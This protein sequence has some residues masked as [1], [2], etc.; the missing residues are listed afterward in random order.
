MEDFE[1]KLANYF[2]TPSGKVLIDGV[3]TASTR[4]LIAFEPCPMPPWLSSRPE[5]RET[6]SPQTTSSIS[7]CSPPRDYKLWEKVVEHTL[8]YLQSIGVT[9]LGYI[10]GH[11][12]NRD[13]L[14]SERE[15]FDYY[16]H[17]AL[18]AKAVSSDAQVGGPGPWH[19]RGFKLSCDD[20]AYN[21]AGKRLCRESGGWEERYREP[22]IKSFLRFVAA[23]PVPLDFI[24]WHSFG[25][26]DVDFGIQARTIRSWLSENSLRQVKLIPS[27][28]TYWSGPYPAD[29]LDSAETASYIVSSLIHMWQGGIEWHGHDYDVQGDN[30]E[31]KVRASRPG[32]AFIGDWSLITHGGRFGGGVVK[33][34]Y[35]AFVAIEKLTQGTAS[36]LAQVSISGDLPLTAVSSITKDVD[37]TKIS[38]LTAYHVPVNKPEVY[39]RIFLDYANTAMLLHAPQLTEDVD[40]MKTCVVGKSRKRK[41]R[42]QLVRSI[43]TCTVAISQDI[44]SR[45]DKEAFVFLIKFATCAVKHRDPAVCLDRASGDWQTSQTRKLATWL[46][47]YLIPRH[48]KVDVELR[49]LPVSGQVAVTT[50]EISK[51]SANACQYNSRTQATS[52]P[53][54]CGRDGKLD[55]MVRS[56]INE[57]KQTVMDSASGYLRSRGYSENEIQRL[58]SWIAD[59]NRHDDIR[60]CMQKVVAKLGYSRASTRANAREDLKRAMEVARDSGARRYYELI[61]KLNGSASV[62]LTG[63]KRTSRQHV[64]GGTYKTTV[65]M[66]PNT[67]LLFELTSAE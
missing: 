2:N 23:D 45:E 35:N 12:P 31:S 13:W 55:L 24:N 58:R 62:S 16:R 53:E 42:E 3:R 47:A 59:C 22:M 63:S 25:A 27:D 9:K 56:A 52:A 61:E 26:P 19:Y 30:F 60:N 41:S 17:S 50:Y 4:L 54:Y 8:R 64:S 39:P 14:G 37:G 65:T 44:R 29:Y 7:E 32:A 57:A 48:S 21:D 46:R 49:N 38:L 67:V 40:R 28:W 20:N 51:E 66:A 6:F 15:F 11:E 10:V 5:R 33:P 34:A 1:E 43:E 18:A 36:R